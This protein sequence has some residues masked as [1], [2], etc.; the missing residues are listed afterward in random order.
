VTT[1]LTSDADGAARAVTDPVVLA[2]GGRAVWTETITPGPTDLLHAWRGRWGVASEVTDVFD[3]TTSA[4]PSCA[5]GHSMTDVAHVTGAVPSGSTLTFR[6]YQQSDGEDPTDDVLV[7]T[8]EA[9]TVTTAG[10]YTSPAVAC[11]KVATYYWREEL[12][13]PGETTPHHVG[14]PRLPNE[15]TASVSVVTTATSTT[16]GGSI[17]DTA[18]IAGAPPQGSYLVFRAYQLESGAE[19]DMIDPGDLE[20]SFESERVPVTGPGRYAGTPFT[21]NRSQ[22]YWWVET[23][24]DAAGERIHTGVLGAAGETSTITPP[25][26]TP[27]PPGATPGP[28]APPKIATTTPRLAFTGASLPWY[29]GGAGVLIGGGVAATWSAGLRR[30]T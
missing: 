24:Y 14:A 27:T 26:T 3:V 17:R 9:V 12:T 8:T 28:T 13:L 11:E 10:D 20:P 19:V 6:V 21:P 2:D 18:D 16:L 22:D 1:T 30:R 25:G 7:A 15:S 23:L 29:L 4:Q 5:I